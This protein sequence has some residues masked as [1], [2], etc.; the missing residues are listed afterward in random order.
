MTRP[1]ASM[2][3][4]AVRTA[5]TAATGE[6]VSQPGLW[7]LITSAASSMS[8]SL[9]QSIA[10]STSHEPGAVSESGSKRF[11][12]MGAGGF[13]FGPSAIVPRHAPT[14]GN[15][16]HIRAVVDG[17]DFADT[18]AAGSEL[19]DQKHAHIAAGTTRAPIVRGTSLGVFLGHPNLAIASPLSMRKGMGMITLLA[20]LYPDKLAAAETADDIV[21][22]V[23]E[24]EGDPMRLQAELVECKTDL[25][26]ENVDPAIVAK[27]Q[28]LHVTGKN[29]SFMNACTDVFGVGG[30]FSASTMQRKIRQSMYARLI[31]SSLPEP[32]WKATINAA[33]VLNYDRLGVN[34]LTPV[35]YSMLTERSGGMDEPAT[36]SPYTYQSEDM[37][38][39]S[40]TEEALRSITLVRAGDDY[41]ITRDTISTHLAGSFIHRELGMQ[42]DAGRRTLNAIAARKQ[43]LATRAVL[44]LKNYENAIKSGD[45]SEEQLECFYQQFIVYQQAAYVDTLVDTV[46][47]INDF[48]TT[49]PDFT[50]GHLYDPSKVVESRRKDIVEMMRM[51]VRP[52]ELSAAGTGGAYTELTRDGG[53][54]LVAPVRDSDDTKALFYDKHHIRLAMVPFLHSGKLISTEELLTSDD[55]DIALARSYMVSQMAEQLDLS[56]PK[57]DLRLA[58][59]DK[60]EL[61]PSL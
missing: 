54:R 7:G 59:A 48:I 45:Y 24:M 47:P 55:P 16:H 61:R 50:D 12:T 28:D 35:E 2:V 18:V 44:A 30:D 29:L 51:T 5:A 26:P 36:T 13:A 38:W 33:V 57:L 9:K 22:L 58:E 53:I 8:A 37:L 52:V 41:R 27:L 10:D 31:G 19:C 46:A 23:D 40:L 11:G 49:H 56:G 14:K 1:T 60:P 32:R 15:V 6:S 39:Q 34:H 17:V 42:T 20:S 25:H 21:D 3:I 43:D 4:T